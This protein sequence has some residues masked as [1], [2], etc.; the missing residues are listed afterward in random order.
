[1]HTVATWRYTLHVH[2]ITAKNKYKIGNCSVHEKRTTQKPQL[3]IYASQFAKRRLN[4]RGPKRDRERE[5]GKSQCL[6]IQLTHAD[7]LLIGIRR[8]AMRFMLLLLP[9][10]LLHKSYHDLTPDRISVSIGRA[11]NYDLLFMKPEKVVRRSPCFYPLSA[12]RNG[13]FY[14]VRR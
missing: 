5:I 4:E 2:R 14:L 7:A 8:L 11:Q 6:P 3:Q 1:M 12:L 10:L 13:H 9:L